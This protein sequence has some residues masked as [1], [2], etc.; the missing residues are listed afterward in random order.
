MN[1]LSEASMRTESISDFLMRTAITSD[2]VPE[3]E[4]WIIN[5]KY[6]PDG[7]FD[8]DSTIKGSFRIFNLAKPGDIK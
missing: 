1:K 5:P 7:S 2:A 3:N 8:E 6:N 4:V